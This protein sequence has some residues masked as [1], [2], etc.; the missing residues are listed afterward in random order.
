M[1]TVFTWKR[2]AKYGYEVSSA[3]DKRFSAFYARLPDGETIEYK[4]Q[5]RVKGYSTI[6]DGKG[7]PPLNK[8]INLWEEYLNLWKIWSKNNLLLLKELSFLV[9]KYNNTLTDKFATTEINQ[10]RALATILN[11][12]NWEIP[13]YK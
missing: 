9:D 6:K 3:G 2:F 11:E 1:K 4:Y 8:D 13:I 7:K 12:I 5:V 10:A